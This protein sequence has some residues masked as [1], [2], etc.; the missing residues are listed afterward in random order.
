VS[1]PD[2]DDPVGCAEAAAE[3]VRALNHTTRSS[4]GALTGPADAYAV[5]G[6]LALLA[7]RLPQALTQLREY[8]AAEHAAGRLRIVDGQHRGDPAAAVTDLAR[9]L[10]WAASSAQALHAALEQAQTTLTW[11]ARTH[12]A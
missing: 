3:A 12:D 7:G 11:A 9:Q 5:L 6:N 4:A 1:T 2:V 8:I 10:C